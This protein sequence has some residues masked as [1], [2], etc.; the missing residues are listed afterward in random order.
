MSESP[1]R[2][3]G[4]LTLLET[5]TRRLGIACGL[6]F[7]MPSGYESA[8]A[9]YEPQTQMIHVNP[10]LLEDEWIS[11][12]YYLLHELAHALQHHR[13]DTL[14]VGVAS[15]LDYVI[16]YNGR[17]SKRVDGQ[18]LD[19]A[20]EG[21]E[22]YFTDLYTN[23]PYEVH[24]ND[25]AYQALRPEAGEPP[26]PGLEALRRFWAPRHQVISAAD[27][28]AELE[29]AYRRIDAAVEGQEKPEV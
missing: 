5:W 20:L 9:S 10:D 14:P 21:P 7:E 16:L 4:L 24:A 26:L 2:R 25:F 3:Q 27:M 22:E 23:L 15:S 28:P 1:E 11:G 17:C 12:A 6:S 8:N 29:R 18:W 19:C 13:P